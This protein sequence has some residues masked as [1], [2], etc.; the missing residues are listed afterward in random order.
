M[1]CIRILLAHALDMLCGLGTI[2]HRHDYADE[3]A[4]AD[5]QLNLDG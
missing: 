4:F 1:R 3:A 2:C 5:F